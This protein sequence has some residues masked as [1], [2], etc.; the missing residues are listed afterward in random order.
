MLDGKCEGRLEGLCSEQSVVFWGWAGREIAVM[1][2]VGRASRAGERLFVDQ[3]SC[4]TLVRLGRACPLN[5]PALSPRTIQG[6]GNSLV[7]RFILPRHLHLPLLLN[8]SEDFGTLARSCQ[9]IMRHIFT[10]FFTS[11]PIASPRWLWR[12]L[13]ATG[14]RLDTSAKPAY[15]R[16]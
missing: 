2:F 13:C 12:K 4:R 15:S 8:Q 11:P 5:L 16:L 14:A 10:S 7:L 3:P 6:L 1:I 9:K